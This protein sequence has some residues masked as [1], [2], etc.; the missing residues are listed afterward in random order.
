MS[1]LSL[2]E[3]ACECG[4]GIK[5]G[6]LNSIRDVKDIAYMRRRTRPVGLSFQ[7]ACDLTATPTSL[8]PINLRDWQ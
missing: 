8:H 5:A 7:I 1:L 4:V 2:A 6:C 3:C